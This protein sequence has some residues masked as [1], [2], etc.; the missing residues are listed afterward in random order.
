MTLAANQILALAPDPASAKAGSQLSAAHHWSNLGKSDAALWG[1][2]QGSGKT[3]YKTQVDLNGP[4]FK[5]TCPSR[6]FP[7]KHGLGLYLLKAAEPALFQDGAEPQWVSDWLGSRQAR[8]EKK[9]D[10]AAA[11]S[12][13]DPAL[14][15]AQ[16]RKREEKREDKVD[17]GMRELQTWLHDLA[18]EGLASVRS[19]GQGPWDAIA[20]RM[21]DA[22]AAPLSRRLRHAG[23]L[24]YQSGRRN[25]DSLVANELASIYLLTQAWQ[26]LDSL[27]SALQADVRALLGW[28]VSQDEVLR[29]PGI[30]GCWQV[31]AQTTFDDERLRVRATWLH[32]DPDARW[33]LLLQYAAGAQGF[34][35]QLAPGTEF[36]GELRFYPGAYPL[37]AQIRR[38]ENTRPLVSLA[39]P[40]SDLDTLL[41]THADALAVQPFLERHPVL[42]GGLVPDTAD[43]GILRDAGGRAIALHPDFR[44]PWHLLALSGGQPLTV[45]GEWDGRSL[46]PLSVWHEGRL[47]NVDGDFV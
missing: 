44:H 35:L 1:E 18:R 8:Q 41:D 36:D 38:Q 6:K 4:A 13:Q 23:G 45:C 21:A 47:L 27:P 26:R 43:H 19:R 15:A 29:Q 28:T 10:T 39:A 22:Q 40:L 34:E 5:C 14:A 32:G 7:C 30:D 17:A 33:A 3:P 16:T 2:C 37:R 11:A 24:L 31:L 46:L 12:T 9:A 20:A 25:A 42:L